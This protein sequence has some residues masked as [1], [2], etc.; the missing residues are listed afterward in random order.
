VPS[1]SCW[2]ASPFTDTIRIVLADSIDAR[3]LAVAR[4]ES[5]RLVARQVSERPC[6][7]AVSP[8]P[9]GVV[10][11]RPGRA[12][13]SFTWTRADARDLLDRGYDAVLTGDPRALEYAAA[14]PDL[15]DHP[16][17]WSRIY[18]FVVKRGASPT[19][20][21]GPGVWRDAIRGE[22]RP[23]QP[24]FW[25]RQAACG[26]STAPPD[27]APPSGAPRMIYVAD[28]D[29]ARG[30]AER[31]VARGASLEPP[32]RRER[33]VALPAAEVR[34]AVALGRDYAVVAIPREPGDAC[35]ALTD[36]GLA[37][38]SP[39]EVIPMLDTRLHLIVRRGRIG[40]TQIGD[41][42]PL[43]DP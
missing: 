42:I 41:G 26:D 9:Q 3:T 19:W 37:G 20:A 11:L 23:T 28:D 33:I 1:P 38:R 32:D 15:E 22:A 43:F 27:S 21:E 5:E 35:T 12:V 14:R 40:V 30:L 31:F 29:A 7:G 36:L 18:A 13:L 34:A 39:R 24:P 6:G 17:P 16:L 2:P 4:N 8:V 10:V 25:W